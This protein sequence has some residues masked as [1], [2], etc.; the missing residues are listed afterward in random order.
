LSTYRRYLAKALE[1]LTE[2]LWTIEIGDVANRHG[3]D[4]APVTP[5]SNG[6]GRE[7]H[8]DNGGST[9]AA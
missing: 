3:P 9:G 4:G 6:H 8:P 5:S 2:L 1:Q 7:Q